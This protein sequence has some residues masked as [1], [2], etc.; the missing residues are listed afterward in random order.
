MFC[1][2]ITYFYCKNTFW[3]KNTLYAM[4]DIVADICYHYWLYSQ[5]IQFNELLKVITYKYL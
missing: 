2:G 5:S 1:F 4:M 3:R